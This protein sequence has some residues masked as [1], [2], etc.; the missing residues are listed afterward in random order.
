MKTNVLDKL[1]KSFWANI[2]KRINLKKRH[3]QTIMKYN[4][5][6]LELL[7]TGNMEL[8]YSMFLN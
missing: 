3:D 8:F 1:F 4:E 7:F 5:F 6:I 2:T